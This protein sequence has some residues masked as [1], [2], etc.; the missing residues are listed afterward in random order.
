MKKE[1]HKHMDQ[2]D[3]KKKLKKKETYYNQTNG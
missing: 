1:S 2:Y 3:L